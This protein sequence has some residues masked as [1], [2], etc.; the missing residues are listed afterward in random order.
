MHSPSH[1]F[2]PDLAKELGVEKAIIIW[3]LQFWIRFNRNRGKN[4]RDGKC[5]TYQAMAD[6]QAYM[7]Y[8]TY[9]SIRY[10]L[11]GL[12]DAG[13]I[14]VANYNRAK[15]DKTLWYAFADE[16]AFAVDEENSKKSYER[17]KPHSSGENPTRDG[18]NPRPIPDTKEED[19]KKG[20]A[21][22]DAS[23][24]RRNSVTSEDR[25]VAEYLFKKLKEKFP[26]ISNP[27]LEEW[28]KHASSLRRINGRDPK[29]IKQVIDWAI[30]D[31]FWCKNILSTRKLRA[32]F[33]TLLVRMTSVENTGSK[34]AKNKELAREVK[35]FLTSKG[36]NNFQIF[37]E[38]CYIGEKNESLSYD[39]NPKEFAELLAKFYN[40]RIDG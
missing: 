22:K 39:M 15:F 27:N 17:G 4:I 7:P 3:H 9:D 20:A 40:V 10:H 12:K 37:T 26:T 14:I 28:A 33:N 13:I 8:F 36:K 11:E 2:D 5:W 25:E 32:Q 38:H 19:T 35:A 31:T 6:M 21:S 1:A 24:S 23:L 34:I 30:E 18:E 16:K 29:L